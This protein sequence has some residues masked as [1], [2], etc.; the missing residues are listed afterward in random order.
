MIC[1]RCGYCCHNYAVRIVDDPKKGIEEGNTVFKFSDGKPC[2]HLAGDK[3]GEY[4]CAVH[5][6]WWYKTTPCFEFNQ[7]E[8]KNSECR[9]GRF[10]LYGEG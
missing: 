3:P 10:I 7:A 2:K 8:E 5:D 4:S 6:E 9:I 1:L